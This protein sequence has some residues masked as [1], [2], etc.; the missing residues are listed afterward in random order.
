VGRL[1][2]RGIARVAWRCV[3]AN[4]SA[5]TSSVRS[6]VPAVADQEF[7]EAVRTSAAIELDKGRQDHK[8]L[9]YGSVRREGLHLVFEFEAAKRPGTTYAYRTSAMPEP[10]EPR[11]PDGV[12]GTLFANWMEI[13][14]A[15]DLELP[16]PSGQAV[17]WVDD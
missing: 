13:V 6:T 1:R 5:S 7:A 10:G 17:T 8:G 11:D 12:A 14:E 4:A 9:I 3:G 15:D 2:L 16:E